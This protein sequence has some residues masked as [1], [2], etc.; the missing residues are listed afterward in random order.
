MVKVKCHFCGMYHTV[1]KTESW[2]CGNCN[3]QWIYSEQV[4]VPKLTAYE[5][6]LVELYRDRQIN[7]RK[8][9]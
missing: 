8:D 7:K 9:F 2:T 1:P 3:A 5:Y 4:F 6:Q